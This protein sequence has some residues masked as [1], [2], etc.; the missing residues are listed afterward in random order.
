MEAVARRVRVEHAHQRASRTAHAPERELRERRGGEVRLGVLYEV[1][2]R[3][4]VV[5]APHE[6]RRRNRRAAP[7]QAAGG[8]G[9]AVDDC[10]SGGRDPA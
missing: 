5:E 4:A 8:G 6:A 9:D 2:F 7:T 1:E 10:L 3:D